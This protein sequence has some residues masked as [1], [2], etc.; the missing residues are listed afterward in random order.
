[1]TPCCCTSIIDLPVSV[2]ESNLERVSGN[3]FR[4]HEF[5]RHD[6]LVKAGTVPSAQRLQD[7]VAS[8]VQ[9]CPEWRCIIRTTN[10]PVHVCDK[11]PPARFGKS[12]S[13]FPSTRFQTVRRLPFCHS[14]VSRKAVI[15]KQ[16]NF[17][18]H[19]FRHLNAQCP[20]LPLPPAPSPFSIYSKA[21]GSIIQGHVPTEGKAS[22]LDRLFY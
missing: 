7:F 14:F 22:K 12:W 18:P 10:G 3:H 17:V 15:P 8:Y 16:V 5:I 20:S 11:G 13:L 6:R 19:L 4:A 1:M 21:P 9:L 2:A